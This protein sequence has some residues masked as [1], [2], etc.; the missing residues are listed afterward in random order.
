MNRRPLRPER[1]ALPSELHPEVGGACEDRTRVSCL[2]NSGPTVERKP[3]GAPRENRTPTLW[4]RKPALHPF[5]LRAHMRDCDPREKG[6]VGKVAL[7]STSRGLQ[8]RAT[9]SQLLPRNGGSGATRTHTTLLKGLAALAGRWFTIHPRIHGT[10]GRDRTRGPRFWRPMLCHLSYCRTTRRP[11]ASL[12]RAR[13]PA[14]GGAPHRKGRAK[15]RAIPQTTI[16]IR[17]IELRAGGVSLFSFQRSARRNA[18]AHLGRSTGNDPAIPWATS[19]CL[20]IRL[21][22]PCRPAG[23]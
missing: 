22:P 9:P 10:A 8:P 7:E 4:L 14:A 20:A 13:G 16:G 23:S 15:P 12:D 2:Q 11:R 21:R 5:Q 19:R 6:M 18:S 17:R 1:S 3:L